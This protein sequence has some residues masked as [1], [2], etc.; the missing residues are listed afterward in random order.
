MAK[1]FEQFDLFKNESD[2]QPA[3]SPAALKKTP[4][5]FPNVLLNSLNESDAR[6]NAVYYLRIVNKTSVK[7]LY[8]SSQPVDKKLFFLSLLNEIKLKQGRKTPIN[9]CRDTTLKQAILLSKR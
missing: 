1:T 9:S 5:P 2:N 6:A 8:S 4:P 7:R 3:P